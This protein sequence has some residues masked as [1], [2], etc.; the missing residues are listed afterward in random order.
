M[1]KR[2]V[3]VSWTIDEELISKINFEAKQL[4][5]SRSYVANEYLRR[6]ILNESV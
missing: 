1:V 3:N 5:R 4:D 2:K 6:V